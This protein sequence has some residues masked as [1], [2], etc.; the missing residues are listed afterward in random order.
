MISR[1]LG[2]PEFYLALTRTGCIH[3]FG[4]HRQFPRGLKPASL[5]PLDGAAKAA[6][7]QSQ[8]VK[9]LVGPHLEAAR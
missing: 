4:K 3:A 8:V 1:R 5:L 2:K 6:P 7:L 9:Q